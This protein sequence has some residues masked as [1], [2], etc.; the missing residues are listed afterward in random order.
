MRIKD[1]LF[2]PSRLALKG[3]CVPTLRR[4]REERHLTQEQLAV[5]ADVSTSTVY[6]IEAGKVRPRPAILRRLARVLVVDPGAIEI[7]AQV[8][9]GDRQTSKESTE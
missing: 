6:H 5:A 2:G 3:C 1:R 9:A 7:G 8:M 4:L